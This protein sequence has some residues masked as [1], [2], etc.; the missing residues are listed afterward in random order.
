MQWKTCVPSG[1]AISVAVTIALAAGCSSD[2]SPDEDTRRDPVAE[3]VESPAT[4][5]TAWDCEDGSS[6][7]SEVRSA[8]DEIFLVLPEESLTLPHV[9]AASG[10]RYE[11]ERITFWVKGDEA[12]LARRSMKINCTRNSR[13]SVIA[14]SRLAGN[15]F[16]GIGNEPGWTLEIGPDIVWVTDYGQTR[17]VVTRPD[18]RSKSDSTTWESELDGQPFSVTLSLGPCHDDMSGE[19]F[20]TV[21]TIVHGERTYRGCGLGLH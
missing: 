17:Y 3:T 13:D 7:V 19:E 15:D 18:S 1:L 12:T 10:A 14:R 4:E 21:V 16:W 8:T 9:V 11:N 6:V 2:P 20:E 5:V